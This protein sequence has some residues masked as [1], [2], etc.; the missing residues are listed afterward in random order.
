MP[1]KKTVQNHGD[2]N[3]IFCKIV[4]KEIPAEIVYE[5][6]GS[7]AFLDINPVH[8]GHLLLIPKQHYPQI[9]STPDS[10]ISH[11]FVTTKLLMPIVQKATESDFVVIT[12]VGTDVPHFHIHIIPRSYDDG[13]AGF[14]PAQKYGSPERM[15]EVAEKIRK[16]I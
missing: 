9:T 11:L 7:L 1:K 14:W 16:E 3:C 6:K 12:I 8:E 13:L 10:A 15:R 4:K 5:D 2:K